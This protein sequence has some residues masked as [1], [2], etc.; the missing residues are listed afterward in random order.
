MFN[1]RSLRSFYGIRSQLEHS[2]SLLVALLLLLGMFLSPLPSAKAAANC[3]TQHQV[4]A[5]ETLAKIGRLY[6]VK[7]TDIAQAN[8]LTNPDHIYVGQTLCIPAAD[9][10]PPPSS[11]CQLHHIVQ[12]GETL[13]RISIRYGI[14]WTVIAQ[15]NNLINPNR[16]YVG[17]SLCIP[18][19]GVSTPPTN[20]TVPTIS[21]VSVVPNQ[22]VTIQAANFPANQQFDVLM[23]AFGNKGI[24]GTYVTSRQSGVGGSFTA[25]YTIPANLHGMQRIAIRLQS[26]AGYNS[27]N[28]FFN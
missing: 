21:I 24:N 16:L 3:A 20:N 2:V 11:G 9:S 18:F 25:T 26:P 15:A 14:N 6:G 12:R 1:R 10:T 23:G 17:Q 22:S 5:G 28:W 7:W 8:N 19:G 13:Y 27:Y 4:K